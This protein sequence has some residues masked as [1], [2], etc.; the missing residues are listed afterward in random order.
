M[1]HC[2]TFP[3]TINRKPENFYGTI[4][5]AND[6]SPHQTRPLKFTTPSLKIL[7]LQLYINNKEWNMIIVYKIFT[8]CLALA[9]LLSNGVLSGL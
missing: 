4:Q 5:V 9:L 6:K 8:S 2:I 7:L 3:S 1:S